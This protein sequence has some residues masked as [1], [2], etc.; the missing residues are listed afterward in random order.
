[1]KKKK[2]KYIFKFPVL[3]EPRFSHGGQGLS[4]SY[5]YIVRVCLESIEYIKFHILELISM[6]AGVKNASHGIQVCGPHIY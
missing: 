3:G 6:S 5:T 1:M 4:T 2:K